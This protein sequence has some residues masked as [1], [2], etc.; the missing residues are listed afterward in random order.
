MILFKYFITINFMRRPMIKFNFCHRIITFNKIGRNF[1]LF[2]TILKMK[3]ILFCYLY[4]NS[5]EKEKIEN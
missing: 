1:F 5:T 3:N 4:I 2:V